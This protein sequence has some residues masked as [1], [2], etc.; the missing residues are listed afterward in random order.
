MTNGPE[1]PPSEDEW[2]RRFIIINLVRIGGTAIVLLGLAIWQSNLVRPGG[3]PSVGLPMALLG[4]II[5]FPGAHALV[6]RWRT[7]PTP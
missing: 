5:S 6:R 3:W 2:R 7:P 1:P 4:L